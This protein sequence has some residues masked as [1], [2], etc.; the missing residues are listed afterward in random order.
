[1][2][3]AVFASA[4]R[5]IPLRALFTTASAENSGAGRSSLEEDK[6]LNDVSPFHEM[7]A[8][9]SVRSVVAPDACVR[10]PAITNPGRVAKVRKVLDIISLSAQTR[11]EASLG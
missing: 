6:V 5:L 10:N 9:V 4:A 2:G 11:R 1:L 7:L 8:D 3:N